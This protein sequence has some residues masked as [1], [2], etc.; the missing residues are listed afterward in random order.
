MAL[1]AEMVEIDVR[2]TRDGVP[3]LFH[4]HHLRRCTDAP[5]R[6]PDRAPWLLADFTWAEVQ[7]LDSGSWYVDKPPFDK[8]MIDSEKL[9]LG[10]AARR[11]G[12]RD[13]KVGVARLDD[14]LALLDAA[15]VACNIELKAIPAYPPFLVTQVLEAVRRTR[16][17]HR[18]VFSSFDHEL[19][20]EL[21]RAVPEVAC[22][23][24]SHDRLADPVRYLVDCVG[25]D[26][27]HP[28]GR[29]DYD[30]LGLVHHRGFG[31]DIFSSRIAALREAGLGI[32]AWTIDNPDD[33]DWLTAAG[34]HGIMS[35][36]PNRLDPAW[37]ARHGAE[38][39]RIQVA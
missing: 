20:R 6:F 37:R 1:G 24:L 14:A 4:D 22:G 7:A 39:T 21:K 30:T 15:G 28:G 27:Y 17:E 2:V 34:V 38:V 13:G 23:V 11:Q 29:P 10:D 5:Q 3:I 33:I 35:D 16:L 36:F 26:T 8:L 9:A 31:V 18:V 19:V 32:L 25:A 12:Y